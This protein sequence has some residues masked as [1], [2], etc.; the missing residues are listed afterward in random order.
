M[1]RRVKPRSRASN[2]RWLES[3]IWDYLSPFFSKYHTLQVGGPSN[4]AVR[5]LGGLS[6]RL[7]RDCFNAQVPSLTLWNAGPWWICALAADWRQG[8]N[9]TLRCWRMCQMAEVTAVGLVGNWS[10]SGFSV[11]PWPCS[12]LYFADA[13][14]HSTCFTSCSTEQLWSGTAGSCAGMMSFRVSVRGK[15]QPRSGMCL[16]VLILW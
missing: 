2:N 1:E 10:V 11:S 5:S 12:L 6:P 14:A 16:P 15:N 7:S 4:T 3:V 9:P 8:G 13:A